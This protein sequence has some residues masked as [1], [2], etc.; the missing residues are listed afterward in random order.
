MKSKILRENGQWVEIARDKDKK[1]TFWRGFSGVRAHD[2]TTWP[3]S[4]IP[5]WKE[6][7]IHAKEIMK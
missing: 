2:I 6:A 3:V 5:T 1:F 4:A 7:I